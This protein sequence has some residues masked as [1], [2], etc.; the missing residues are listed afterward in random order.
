[1][2]APR[3]E[4]YGQAQLEALADGCLLASTPAPGPYSALGIARRL[5]AGLIDEDL[6]AALSRALAHPDREGYAARALAELAPSRA[7]AVDALVAQEL[8]PRLLRGT[9]AALAA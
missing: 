1:V 2:M 9:S 3:R 6:P 7:A 5:D 4:D 8:L